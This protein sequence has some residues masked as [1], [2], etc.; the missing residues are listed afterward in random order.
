[1]T[2]SNEQSPPPDAVARGYEGDDLSIRGLF[3]FFILFLLTAAIIHAFIWVL[4]LH[5]V[6]S[7]RVEDR[8]PSSVNFVERFPSPQL[9]PSVGHNTT[10]P[11]DL[12]ALR[13]E[14]GRIF[15]A[16]GWK[17]DPQS[18]YLIIPDQILQE[19]KHREATTQATSRAT[20]EGAK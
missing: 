13:L 14:E 5:Y 4:T 17:K 20:K 6:W 18:S 19:L 16:L 15:D 10:P 12:A 11:Q 7:P 2:Q 9:Q 1:V 8:A 3:I